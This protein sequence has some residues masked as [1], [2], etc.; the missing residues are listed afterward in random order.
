MSYKAIL[1][2][3]N[4]L[5]TEIATLRTKGVTIPL[6][7]DARPR[8]KI[9]TF[10]PLVYTKYGILSDSAPHVSGRLALRAIMASETEDDNALVFVAAET[11]VA[12]YG[13][14]LDGADVLNGI[15]SAL[16]KPELAVFTDV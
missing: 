2:A 4:E 7:I 16:G 10:E 9:E 12:I 5:N 6:I 8:F 14:S 15:A 3:A 1:D 11:G 13:F